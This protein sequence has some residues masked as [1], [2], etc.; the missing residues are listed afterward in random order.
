MD[1]GLVYDISYVRKLGNTIMN[2]RQAQS[3]Q[4]E[5]ICKLDSQVCGFPPV[6]TIRVKE[7][8]QT[9]ANLVFIGN[10]QGITIGS[11]EMVVSWDLWLIAG[12]GN[13]SSSGTNYSIPPSSYVVTEPTESNPGVIIA[14][15]PQYVIIPSDYSGNGVVAIGSDT[16]QGTITQ[17]PNYVSTP[18]IPNNTW[19]T[20]IGGDETI[21]TWVSDGQIEVPT[22]FVGDVLVI[23]GNDTLTQTVIETPDR[24]EL[25]S[26]Y[27]PSD[28]IFIDDTIP[29]S[30]ESDDTTP[31]YI[32]NPVIIDG[33]DTLISAWPTV[34]GVGGIA[35]LKV[36]S[37]ADY[38]SYGLEMRTVM[39]RGDGQA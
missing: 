28:S 2:M 12:D 3:I 34:V 27:Y 10:S 24:I 29:A 17:I 20:I 30:L 4:Y 39:I 38:L 23:S 15:P 21:N 1:L 6:K 5:L 32:T 18:T 8:C 13:T 36:Q 22:G 7:S 33:D 25:P 11:D 16:V 31:V 19:V 26:G 9:N 35:R 14:P 37:H